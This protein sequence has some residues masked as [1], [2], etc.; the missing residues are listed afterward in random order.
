MFAR[1]RSY[2]LAKADSSR[3]GRS[4]PSTAREKQNRHIKARQHQHG[5][6]ATHINILYYLPIIAAFLLYI[7][8]FLCVVSSFHSFSLFISSVSSAIAE[9]TYIITR[10]GGGVREDRGRPTALRNRGF[11]KVE[12]KN[13]MGSPL[14]LL[15]V[16]C[17]VFLCSSLVP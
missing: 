6:R 5:A 14:L 16:L 7:I 15:C 10:C 8:A 3:S 2:S 1:V 11:R 12:I 17:V 9:S 4:S 13:V